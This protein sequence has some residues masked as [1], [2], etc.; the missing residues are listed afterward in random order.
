MRFAQWRIE[1]TGH[2]VIGFITNHAYLDNPTFRGMRHSLM[3]TFDEI[4]VL[5]P[6][7]QREEEGKRTRRRQGRKRVRHPARHRHQLFHEA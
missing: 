5:K 1:R 4:Y 7:W 6:P 3:Q 2:G